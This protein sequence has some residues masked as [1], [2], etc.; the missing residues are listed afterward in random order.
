MG[1]ILDGGGFR[2]E[3]DGNEVRLAEGSDRAGV[4]GGG[5]DDELGRRDIPDG[6]LLM[7][8]ICSATP[9]SPL[10]HDMCA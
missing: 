7:K 6:F 3:G 4:A 2:G 10:R 8:T 1:L 9:A 5:L